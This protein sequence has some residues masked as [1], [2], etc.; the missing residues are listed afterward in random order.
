MKETND[1]YLRMSP[2]D[3]YFKSSPDQYRELF[4]ENISS[5]DFASIFNL[6]PNPETNNIEANYINENINI[7]DFNYFYSN[8]SYYD[9]DNINNNKNY[10]DSISIIIHI[11]HLIFNK[12]FGECLKFFSEN[13]SK[14]TI[15]IL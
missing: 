1:Y 3:K 5:K 15:I 11:K 2:S 7:E 13:F 12:N 8:N 10:I 6:S 9:F 14:V 4:K